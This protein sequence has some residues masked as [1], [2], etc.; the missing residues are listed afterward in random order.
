MRS[1][2]FCPAPHACCQG[3]A[4]ADAVMTADK[5]DWKASTESKRRQRSSL[6]CLVSDWNSSRLWQIAVKPTEWRNSPEVKHFNVTDTGR[7]EGFK[8]GCNSVIL[9]LQDIQQW[10][11]LNLG[12]NVIKRRKTPAHSVLSV[13]TISST[14]CVPLGSVVFSCWSGMNWNFFKRWK[15]SLLEALE[16]QQVENRVSH[17]KEALTA[18]DP[19]CF[20]V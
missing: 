10:S 13:T 4:A 19:T 2:T 1:G 12:V 8:L 3:A 11:N 7:Q 18:F 20:L 14:G 9:F 17:V 15:Q 16:A 5:H 6:V